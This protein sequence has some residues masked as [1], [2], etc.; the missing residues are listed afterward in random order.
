MLCSEGGNRHGNVAAAGAID[1]GVV[2][3]APGLCVAEGCDHVQTAILR[4]ARDDKILRPAWDDRILRPAGADKVVTLR[5]GPGMKIRHLDSSRLEARLAGLDR[6]TSRQPHGTWPRPA[7]VRLE[8]GRSAACHPAFACGEVGIGADA[9]QLP[10]RSLADPTIR[11][12]AGC[13]PVFA[14]G[15]RC[16]RHVLSA[17]QASLKS[18]RTAAMCGLVVRDPAFGTG[19]GRPLLGIGELPNLETGSGCAG[20]HAGAGRAEVNLRPCDG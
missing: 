4:P 2:G 6:K 8:T 16:C 1:H 12:G 17:A 20:G 5:R 11:P 14:Q 18:G 7:D 9:P 19:T 13:G 15:E 10:P 3:T